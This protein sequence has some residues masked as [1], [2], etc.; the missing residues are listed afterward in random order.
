MKTVMFAIILIILQLMGNVQCQTSSEANDTPRLY[1]SENGDICSDNVDLV[2]EIE[3][4]DQIH[5]TVGMKEVCEQNE[6]TKEVCHSMSVKECKTVFK[7][8]ASV[9]KVKI[10]SDSNAT[11]STKTQRRQAAAAV[12]GSLRPAS[13]KFHGEEECIDGF[14]QVCETKHESVCNTVQVK[15]EMLEDHPVCHIERVDRCGDSPDKFGQCRSVPAMRCKIEQRTV[16]KTRPETKCDRVP[17]T[18]CHDEKCEG[19]SEEPVCYFR[20]QLVGFYPSL[21]YEQLP[22]CMSLSRRSKP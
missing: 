10:C 13:P 20:D 15:H 5:C 16:V 9:V 2:Q 7:P 18:F 8:Q 6:S 19:F 14:R 21:F 4:D 12:S 17:R 11:E 1:I 3:Y 22:K